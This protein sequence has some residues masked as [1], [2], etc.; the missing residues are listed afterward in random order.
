MANIELSDTRLP[1]IDVSPLVTGTG[2]RSLVASAMVQACRDSGFFYTSGTEEMRNCSAGATLAAADRV[3]RW[4]RASVHEFEGTY[5]NYI[6][7]KVSKVFPQLRRSVM[8]GDT[9]TRRS[10]S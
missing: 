2:D 6:L 8:N 4:D 5:G 1:V 9:E 3:E 10:S 7:A